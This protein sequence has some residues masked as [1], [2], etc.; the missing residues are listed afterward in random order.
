MHL[1]AWLRLVRKNRFRVHPTRWGLATTITLLSGFNSAMRAASNLLYSQQIAQ[2]ELIQPPV[3]IVGHWRSGTTY[4]HELMS[5]DRRFATPSN[6]QCFAANHF[7]VTESWLPKMVWFL[8][9]AQRPMDNVQT[10]WDSPQE[11]EFALCSLGSLSP[12][13]RIAFPNEPH[14]YWEYLDVQNLAEAERVDWERILTSFLGA[15][16]VRHQKRIILKSPTHTA[17]VA[18]LARIFPGSRFVH[19]VR[20][21]R[22]I[23]LST[24]NL[25]R[26]LDEAQALQ[27]PHHRELRQY[28]FEALQRMYDAFESQ[29][30]HLSQNQIIDVRYEDLVANPVET[31]EQIYRSLELDDFEPVRASLQAMTQE[32]RR[33]QTNRYELDSDTEAEILD[34]WSTYARK[35]GYA[36]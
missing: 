30:I 16:T 23:F 12:Y 3:F 20:D 28:V 1:S 18:P 33:Y 19:I 17:R 32:K 11:D 22:T 13:L 10:S 6:Y 9:P 31:M 36:T 15:L 29:R 35:Y 7:L 14:R 34:R 2:T 25:W 26:V 8:M 4:L 21:P 24:M 27:R 5:C